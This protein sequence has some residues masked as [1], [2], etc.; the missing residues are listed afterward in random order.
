MNSTNDERNS[1]TSDRRAVHD[2][3]ATEESQPLKSNLSQLF[4]KNEVVPLERDHLRSTSKPQTSSINSVTLST[5]A[6][7]KVYRL[8]TGHEVYIS[9][10]PSRSGFMLPDPVAMWRKYGENT[11]EICQKYFREMEDSRFHRHETTIL[12]R[13]TGEKLVILEKRISKN[14]YRSIF[15]ILLLLIITLSLQCVTVHKISNL[16]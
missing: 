8:Q 3:L 14:L 5:T 2:Q 12:E 16:S 9:S 11:M 7:P 1:R 13:A 6:D 10:E 15:A 4:Q